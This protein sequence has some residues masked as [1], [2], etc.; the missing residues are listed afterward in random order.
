MKVWLNMME[1]LDNTKSIRN[2]AKRSN[3]FNPYKHSL[4]TRPNW[5]K[6]IQNVWMHITTSLSFPWPFKRSKPTLS[7]KKNTM[8]QPCLW[9]ILCSHV[10]HCLI[11]KLRHH[12]WKCITRTI[13][14]KAQLSNGTWWILRARGISHKP[15]KLESDMKETKTWSLHKRAT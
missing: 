7:H 6:K 9:E 5:N 12:G 4:T 13:Q 14:K 3:W 15:F 11:L 8:I 1:P 2:W 10:W